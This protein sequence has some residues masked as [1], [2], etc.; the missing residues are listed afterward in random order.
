MTAGHS[1]VRA[2]TDGLQTVKPARLGI[3]PSALLASIT[4]R[5]RI[6]PKSLPSLSH[7][8]TLT[9]DISMQVNPVSSCMDM[10]PPIQGQ[11]MVEIGCVDFAACLST[12]ELL[13]PQG[14]L[15][16]ID[17]SPATVAAARKQAASTGTANVEFHLCRIDSI[18]LSSSTCDWVISRAP[19]C[20]AGSRM[21][22]LREISRV[23]KPGGNM[24]LHD[25]AIKRLL[26]PELAET[27]TAHSY[28][29]S[30]A[31]EPNSYE[32]L[33][34]KAGLSGIQM[35]LYDLGHH[36]HQIFE[37]A[38]GRKPPQNNPVSRTTGVVGPTLRW[39]GGANAAATATHVSL[40]QRGIPPPLASW[41]SDG[42]TGHK[43]ADYLTAIRIRAQ[44]IESA[45]DRPAH[46]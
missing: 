37:P 27:L 3:A 39:A 23:L 29:L 4:S 17:S 1:P 28:G 13:G 34:L 6:G 7:N 2:S 36:I 44:R 8:R 18:P 46:F 14:K 38:N 19:V 21:A 32:K 15:V 22:V 31:I 42:Q 9:S 33:L 40:R 30:G 11:I 26:P 25:V 35:E 41:H 43:L 10:H 20:M 45:S 24:I 12:A 5:F 16:A